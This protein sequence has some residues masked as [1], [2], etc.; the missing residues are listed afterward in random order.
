[1]RK[2]SSNELKYEYSSITFQ[3][4]F[5]I[6]ILQTNVGIAQTTLPKPDHIVILTLEN[7]SFDQII[8]SPA[9]PYI[10]KLAIDTTSALFTQSYGTSH[11]SQ[12][13]YLTLYSGSDQGVTDDLIPSGIPFTTA[14]LGRQL[15]DSGKSYNTYSEDLPS[16]G[17]DG[18]LFANYARRHNPAANWMGNGTNQISPATNQPF[19][20][21]LSNDFTLLPTVCFV[22][23]N[24]SNDMHD[25]TDPDRIT[26]CD[27][28]IYNNMDTYINWAKGNNSLFILTFDEDN[29]SAF[30]HITTIFTGKVVLS[31]QYSTKI[32]HYSILHTIEKIYGLPF[33]GDSISYSPITYCWRKNYPQDSMSNIKSEPNGLIYPNPGKDFF[34]IYLSKYQDATAD[35]FDLNGI[36]IQTIP[37]I[38]NKTEI[39]IDN[40]RGGLYLVKINS[41][42][43]IIQKK[44]I[45]I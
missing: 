11:P 7:H 3:V 19:T 20:A 30:N 8:G 1:M 10:N 27:N 45:K 17:Y 16:V 6:F 15:I 25:G 43:G 31:G 35:I 33:I 42:G 34:Y 9:A 21:F 24:V 32:N 44:F 5:I 12:P 36:L 38:S 41:N 37:L 22:Q 4:F 40:L 2:N 23:P 39:K 18:E 28:W 13:N 26:T 14:N 29:D